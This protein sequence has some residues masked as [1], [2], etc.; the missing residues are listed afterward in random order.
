MS[1]LVPKLT[2]ARLETGDLNGATAAPVLG[3]RWLV[4]AALVVPV[5]LAAGVYWLHNVPAGPGPRP[6]D[7]FIEVRLVSSA[8][9]TDLRSEILVRQTP[10][11]PSEPLMKAPEQVI[12]QSVGAPSL[13]S[14]EPSPP[15]TQKLEAAAP[16][17][18]TQLPANRAALQF[19]RALFSHIAKYQHYPKEARNAGIQGAVQIVFT[20]RRDGTLADIWVQTSS[21][22]AALDAA[23]L[24]TVRKA[25]PLPG[26]PN[27]L[28]DRLNILIPVAFGASNTASVK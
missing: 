17:A 13:A 21:G 8:A 25:Q 26:I 18:P 7:S 9:P 22:Y 1:N 24:D 14:L 23:A 4:G 15:A 3:F 12:D 27:E 28:P 5:L 10:A 19:R 6:G 2:R 16:A 11:P 20:M